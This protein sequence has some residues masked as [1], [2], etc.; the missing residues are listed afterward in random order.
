MKILIYLFFVL[1]LTTLNSL[2]CNCNP[3]GSI[4]DNVSKA[5]VI[6]RVRIIGV[7]Y[8]DRL[9]TFSVVNEGDPTSTFN[10]YWK[11][12]MKIYTALVEETY[13]GKVTS[14]TIRIATGMNGATCTLAMQVGDLFLVYGT[15]KDYLGFSSVQRKATDG[16]FIFTNSCTRSMVFLED[17]FTVFEELKEVQKEI[18]LQSYRE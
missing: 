11:F 15:I 7:T 10:K 14:D 1:F 8:S 6:A 2:A 9:D 17:D 18:E 3:G 4:Q 13:K 16:K 5:N 12:H